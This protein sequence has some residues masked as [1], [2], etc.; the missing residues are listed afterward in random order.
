[1]PRLER[2]VYKGLIT[3]LSRKKPSNSLAVKESPLL[4]KFERWSGKRMKLYF[5]SEDSF[6]HYGLRDLKLPHNMLA[7]KLASPIRAE[8][9]TRYRIP[10]EFLI[11]LNLYKDATNNVLQLKANFNGVTGLGS[12]YIHNNKKC[13]EMKFCDISRWSSRQPLK[14][15]PLPVVADKSAL[16]KD[17][18]NQLTR[19]LNEFFSKLKTTSKHDHNTVK[20]YVSTE[21]NLLMDVDTQ[22]SLCI[23]LQ[24][25]TDKLP[26]TMLETVTNAPIHISAYSNM[27]FL[28][29]LHRLLGYY[30]HRNR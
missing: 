19:E 1:M 8:R 2:N 18:E 16:L 21:N 15:P 17:Y 10:K 25:I 24:S 29:T 14:V 13:L 30:R 9:N 6:E 27:D 20:L 28:T 22:G 12:T 23:N 3:S 26:H 4:T 11:K 5:E 7:N